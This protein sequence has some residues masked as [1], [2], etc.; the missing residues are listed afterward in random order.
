MAQHLDSR[1][2]FAIGSQHLWCPG[3]QPKHASNPDSVIKKF[4]PHFIYD[5]AFTQADAIFNH[6]DTDG[7]GMHMAACVALVVATD[8]VVCAMAESAAHNITSNCRLRHAHIMHTLPNC[9]IIC[10]HDQRTP[11]PHRI[12]Q[13]LGVVVVWW[14]SGVDVEGCTD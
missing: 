8:G 11:P 1:C 12:T 4:H 7:S 9:C 13:P 2:V 6:L 10:A 3:S 14:C 5:T